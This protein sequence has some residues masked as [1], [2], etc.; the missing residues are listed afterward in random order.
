MAPGLVWQLALRKKQSKII[1]FNWYQY[2]GAIYR[3]AK[4]NNKC[5]KYYDENKESSYFPYCDVNN[6]TDRKCHKSYL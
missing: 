5:M 1:S 2:N 6:F 3:Y 4:A